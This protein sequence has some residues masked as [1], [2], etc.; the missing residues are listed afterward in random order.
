MS[1]PHIVHTRIV[2]RLNTIITRA[3]G[4]LAIVTLIVTSQGC[5]SSS[6]YKAGAKTSESVMAS[7]KQLDEGS[8]QIDKVGASLNKLMNASPTT[9]LRPLFKEYSSN[10]DKL[11]AMAKHAKKQAED[12]RAKGQTYFKDWDAELAKAIS[13]ANRRRRARSDCWFDPV[14]SGLWLCCLA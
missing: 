10:V 5:S 12:M 14:P 3:L 6:G 2:H 9:N 11:D 4:P 8:A 1:L 13:P 7:A